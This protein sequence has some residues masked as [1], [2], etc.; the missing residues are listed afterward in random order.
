MQMPVSLF[1]ESRQIA[2][3]KSAPS[4]RS[5]RLVSVFFGKDRDMVFF[6]AFL[7]ITTIVLPM[8]TV[9]ECGL[10]ALAFIFALTIIS[11][12][13]ATIHPGPSDISLPV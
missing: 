13:F 3:Q 5:R 4:A 10:V 8:T 9:S 6:L 7:V 11:G 12:A 2:P 1:P